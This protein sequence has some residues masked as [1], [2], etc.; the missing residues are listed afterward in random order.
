[1]AQPT[2]DTQHEHV[3]HGDGRGH[4]AG[5]VSYDGRHEQSAPGLHVSTAHLL[6]TAFDEAREL[7]RVELV[8]ARKEIDVDIKAARRAAIS[9]TISVAVAAAAFAMAGVTIMLAA[10]GTVLVAGLVTGAYFAVAILVALG[11]KAIAP[12]RPL[13][14]TRARLEQDVKQ[15]AER[16]P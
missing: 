7:M 12:T 15:F 3:H 9:A 6:R 14:E 16:V 8:M 2:H 11:A 10:G 1:M 13:H 4:R 5:R